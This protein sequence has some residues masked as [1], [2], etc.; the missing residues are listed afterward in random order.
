MESRAVHFN[1][2]SSSFSY[3]EIKFKESTSVKLKQIKLS[4]KEIS[5]TRERN[6]DFL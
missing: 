4:N 6:R 2:R 5:S 1:K 3:D